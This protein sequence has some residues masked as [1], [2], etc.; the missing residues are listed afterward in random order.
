[1]QP[2]G[3]QTKAHEP[4][5]EAPS[6]PSS[7]SSPSGYDA[8]MIA[9]SGDEAGRRR[10]TSPGT[11]AAERMWSESGA[12]AAVAARGREVE[13]Q[14]KRHVVPRARYEDGEPD[15]EHDDS[16]ALLGRHGAERAAGTPLP[17]MDGIPRYFRASWPSAYEHVMYFVRPATDIYFVCA[18]FFLTF[19]G[20]SSDDPATWRL[21]RTLDAHRFLFLWLPFWWR[22][23]RSFLH[24]VVSLAI[25]P[26]PM[27]YHEGPLTRFYPQ[28]LQ[29][30]L[31]EGNMYRHVLRPR[32]EQAG[33][34]T[35][36][37]VSAD[38]VAIDALY[39]RGEGA[40]PDGPTVIR[41]NGNAE[42]IEMQDE[43][44]PRIYTHNG[45]NLLLF[46]YRGV[47]RSRWLRV[48]GNDLAG[49]VLGLWRMPAVNGT[50]M[51]AWTVLE[52]VT[53]ELK[54][55]PAKVVLLGHSIGG[56]I[57]THLAANQPALPVCLCNSRSF[58][59]LSAVAVHLAPMFVGVPP[60]T[61]KAKY[62]RWVARAGLCLSGWEYRSLDNWAR[63]QGFKWLEYSASD[64]IIPFE[65]SLFQCLA[66]QR[67]A[68]RSVSAG[69]AGR[70]GKGEEDGAD[71]AP[72][73]APEGMRA[74]ALID[75]DTDNH[76]RMLFDAE[77][78]QH[79]TLM[80]EAVGWAPATTDM[81]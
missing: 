19:L 78:I 64:H 4:A 33:G 80:L 72:A 69:G 15:D 7:P 11:N 8:F 28:W 81:A 22:F 76:N 27:L 9:G 2:E 63:V 41:F 6:S 40:S 58:G 71:A 62:L 52:Y 10:M 16:A 31:K 65:H 55:P 77:L 35:L 73:T 48:M 36:Q 30:S 56:A 39:F 67:R 42:A 79:L 70:A 26:G 23:F 68:S 74:I 75:L 61:P 29:E 20:P 34:I 59:Y 66:A 60:G 18:L 17:A 12:P 24:F 37:L 1:M 53:K 44:L 49:S 21:W 57:A 43:I 25:I 51:D 47:G 54:V 13:L 14:E 32:L 45:L 5:D 38:G 46:N 3:E 50:G